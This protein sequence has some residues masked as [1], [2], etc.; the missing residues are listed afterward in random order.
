VALAVVR[1]RKHGCEMAV[2]KERPP[3][4][5]RQIRRR[6]QEAADGRREV[7]VLRVV[8]QLDALHA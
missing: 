7:V 1:L 3:P 2:E 5:G 8:D 6:M 4:L